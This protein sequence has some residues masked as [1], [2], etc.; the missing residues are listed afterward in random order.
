MFHVCLRRT[1]TGTQ[2]NINETNHMNFFVSQE[3]YAYINKYYVYTILVSS[4]IVLKT[5]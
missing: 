1:G 3:V 2:A 4:S 5:I